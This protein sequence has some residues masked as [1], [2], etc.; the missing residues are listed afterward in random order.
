MLK[1]KLFKYTEYRSKEKVEIIDDKEEYLKIYKIINQIIPNI[2]AR[3]KEKPKIIPKKMA[4]P[5]PPLNFSQI[6]YMWPIKQ[7]KAAR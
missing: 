4:T 2:K 6:G 7:I 3:L 5:L 1:S